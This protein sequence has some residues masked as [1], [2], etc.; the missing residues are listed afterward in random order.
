MLLKNKIQN[1]VLP[2]YFTTVSVVYRMHTQ[3]S[4]CIEYLAVLLL[5]KT[6]KIVFNNRNKAEI[7]INWSYILIFIKQKKYL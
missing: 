1:S 4:L 3:N 2:F 5:A 6:I 7:K